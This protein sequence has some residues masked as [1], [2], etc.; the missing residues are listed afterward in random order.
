MDALITAAARALAAG[1]PLGALKR[2]TPR[3]D[4]PIP[5]LP[6]NGGTIQDRETHY[7]AR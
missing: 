1:D 6:H 7:S 2:V 4:P 3:D 5:P